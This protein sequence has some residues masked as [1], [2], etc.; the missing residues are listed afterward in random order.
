MRFK[1]RIYL[2]ATFQIIDFLWRKRVRNLTVILFNIEFITILFMKIYL[3]R[4]VIQGQC[5][6]V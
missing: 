1:V 5:T 3:S 4:N 2:H 6:I